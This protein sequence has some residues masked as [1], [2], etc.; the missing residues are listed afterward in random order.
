M[1]GSGS[2]ASCRT[3]PQNETSAVDN[4]AAN[5]SLSSLCARHLEPIIIEQDGPLMA[6]AER[7][8]A[9][10]GR[11]HIWGKEIGKKATISQ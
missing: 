5:G 9:K 11:E 10:Y 6:S 7:G 2:L 4:A 3:R 8:L 1:K